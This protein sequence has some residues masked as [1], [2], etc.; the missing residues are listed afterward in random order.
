VN[1]ANLEKILEKEP[2]YRAH[3]VKKAIFHDLIDDWKGATTLPFSLRERLNEACPLNIEH[4]LFRS[5][6]TEAAKA[7]ITLED[8]LKIESVLMRHKDGRNTVCVSS[9]VGCPLGCLFC[10]TGKM[11]FERNLKS[12]EIVEQVLLFSRYLK[13]SKKQVTNVV[14]MGMGEPF[15]NY[16]NVMESV[17]TMHEPEVFNMGARRFSISTVGITDG[18]RKLAAEP[19]EVNLAISLHAPTDELRSRLMPVNAK[20]SISRI[21]EAV[22]S[23]AKTTNRRVMFEYIMIKDFND[24]EECA[25][26]LASLMKKPLYF[27]NL[28]SYNPAVRGIAPSPA[29]KV[30]KF[31]ETLQR[32]GI[33]VTERFRF[34]QD[35]AAACGQLAADEKEGKS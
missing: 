28:I 19:L 8:G 17:K 18:I 7:L 15:L 1:L 34:G 27:V 13:K 2:E 14:F 33:A 5:K 9:Q 20:Y 31:K 6:K 4:R 16:E 21:L 35:I 26:Q 24:S 32:K 23:Y 29:A 22:E 10:A 3:Q 11:K 25:V 30:R 12:H